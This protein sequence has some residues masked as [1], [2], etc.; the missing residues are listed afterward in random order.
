MYYTDLKHGLYLIELQT[1]CDCRIN[2][3]P[4]NYVRISGWR[5]EEVRMITQR[6]AIPKEMLYIFGIVEE[7]FTY[8]QTKKQ[9]NNQANTRLDNS[10]KLQNNHKKATNPHE[11]TLKS[12]LN[13]MA[14]G[15]HKCVC[16]CSVTPVAVWRTSSSKWPWSC[17][18]NRRWT[19][20]LSSPYREYASASSATC[21]TVSK[22][23]QQPQR[24][25]DVPAHLLTRTVDM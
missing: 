19:T 22:A 21:H 3:H 12:L 14:S 15:K 1:N 11:V 23:F 24:W 17:F 13:S 18:S 16:L 8:K 9:T 6:W 7:Q 4:G 2:G 20:S 25:G 5:L 10:A